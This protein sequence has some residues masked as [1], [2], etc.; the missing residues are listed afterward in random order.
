MDRRTCFFILS[1]PK[2]LQFKFKSLNTNDMKVFL[3]NNLTELPVSVAT[4]ADLV[5][6]KELPEAATAVA[7]DNRLIMRKNWEARQLK[8]QEQITLISAAFGG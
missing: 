7:I 8:D 5:R 6:W 2:G 1:T 3:N 4:V